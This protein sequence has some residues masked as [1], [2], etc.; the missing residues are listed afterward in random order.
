MK[1]SP[2]L[3]VAQQPTLQSGY[4]FKTW[5]CVGGMELSIAWVPA[6]F[7]RGHGGSWQS[8]GLQLGQVTGMKA[9]QHLRR[10]TAL[11]GNRSPAQ[12]ALCAYQ[13]TQYINQYIQKIL[14]VTI[15]YSPL[16]L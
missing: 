8:L 12:T 16:S 10:A 7:R 5:V 6:L 1:K 9:L 14:Q 3:A 2:P 13:G 11:E 4:W 15:C